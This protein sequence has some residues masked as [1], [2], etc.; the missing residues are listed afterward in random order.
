[1][2]K[3]NIHIAAIQETKLTAKSKMRETPNYTLV[4]KDRE[5]DKGGG[6][7][8]L[9]HESISF[10]RDPTPPSLKD[11]LH[12]EELTI[13]LNCKNTPLQIRNVYIPPASSCTRGYNAPVNKVYDNLNNTSLILGDFNAHHHLWHSEAPED[14]RG[15]QIADSIA[16]LPF[17][18]LNEDQPTRATAN[19]ETSPDI[20]IS[21]ISLLPVC[22]WR[23]D[24]ALSSDHLP[25][26][27]HLSSEVIKTNAP[28]KTFMNFNK[29]D[30]EG[31]T[32]FTE[33]LFAK[34]TA[35]GDAI[36]DEKTF[37]DIVQRGAKKSIPAGRIP[38]V[39]NAMPTAA[40]TLTEE[41]NNLRK[42]NPTDPRIHQ[43]NTEIDKLVNEHR[44]N[45]W[46][47][48]LDN[49]GPGT[50]KLWDTIKT[51]NCGSNKQPVNQG[52]SFNKKMY[53]DPKKLA[54]NF[55]TL[56]TP[57]ATTKPSKES[58]AQRRALQKT[59]PDPAI[60]ITEANTTEAIKKSKSSK[61]LGPDELSPVMLKH[62]GPKGIAYLTKI[63]NAVVNTA[64]IPHIWKVGKI[65]P[66][67]KPKKPADEGSSYRPVSLLCPAAKLLESTLLP[68]ITTA[69]PLADHQH[70]FRKKRS[71]TTALQEISDHITDGLNRK[72]P[73]HRTVA[74]A[75]DL[76]RAFDT[77]DHEIL[78]KEVS[79]L[80]LNGHIKRFITGYLRGRQTY[81]F[82]RGQK[83]KYRKMRQGVPQ[84]GGPLTCTLQ[85]IHEQ[86]AL[87]PRRHKARHL[88]G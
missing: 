13:S 41:R 35:T 39:Y 7:A 69:I 23:V 4:R 12:T 43:L 83:S 17:G 46:S 81:V 6:V 26:L 44:K 72:K 48:H 74:V 66:L 2:E 25:I 47:E 27:I 15:S 24:S 31:F 56:Y 75:I 57:G 54:D 33:D 50:K 62:L 19:S 63:F 22:S 68:T 53:V 8:F 16:E 11:D 76:S 45:T 80:E 82:F 70:G 86:D 40:A 61:A 65:I 88:R 49:C 37:R 85:P 58:R 30:W 42:S 38:K 3:N 73:A 84:G 28:Q 64:N 51:L 79:N 18:I 36:K 67:L 10:H 9:V 87:P 1:M 21:S 20:S 78:I 5:K 14:A 29:A 60:I 55:N 77:V 32:Q 52:I 59:P 71:T 34:A